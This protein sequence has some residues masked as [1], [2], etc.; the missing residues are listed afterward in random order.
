MLESLPPPI[1]GAGNGRLKAPGGGVQEAINEIAKNGQTSSH[2]VGDNTDDL[3]PDLSIGNKPAPTRPKSSL[4]LLS[5][6]KGVDFRPYLL[7]VLQTIRMN[8]RSVYP[9]SARLGSRGRVVL[10]FAVAPRRHHHQG[11]VHD[12]I[13]IASTR[14]CLRRRH[15]HVEP[16]A[17][18]SRR[19]YGRAHCAATQIPLQRG[20]MKPTFRVAMASYAVLA[21]IAVIATEGKIRL[22]LLI[23]LVALAVKTWIARAAGW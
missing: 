8:W 2:A 3:S 15:Q 10:Q 9:E 20:A 13:R 21:L 12:G 22:A 6:P 23:L 17:S 5:D 16:L 4:E 14:S 7:Q 11:R 18:A 19:V 1:T